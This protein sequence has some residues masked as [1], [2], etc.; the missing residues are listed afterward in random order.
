MR[1]NGSSPIGTQ[2]VVVPDSKGMGL[3][4]AKGSRS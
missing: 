3:A 4:S 1:I 2:S